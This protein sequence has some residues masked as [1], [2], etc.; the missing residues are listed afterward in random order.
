MNDL[1]GQANEVSLDLSHPFHA[2]F[3]FAAVGVAHDE[4]PAVGLSAENLDRLLFGITV[5]RTRFRYPTED[6]G[7]ASHIS[8]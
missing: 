8:P 2:D 1:P 7:E 5:S 6:P 3:S 4:L